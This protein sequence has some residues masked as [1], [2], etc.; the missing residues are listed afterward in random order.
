MKLILILSI[1]LSTDLIFQEEDFDLNKIEF[2][3]LSFFVTKSE[4][5]TK[6]G[7]PRINEP[8]Y[9]CGFYSNDQPS[10]PFYQLV[11]EDFNYIGSDQEKFL[12]EEVLF[13]KEG[14]ITIKYDEQKLNGLTTKKGFA[15]IFG[16]Y[17]K[18]LIDKYPEEKAFILFSNESDDGARFTFE[19]GKLIKFEY[20]SPC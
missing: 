4:V 12:L 13:D 16:S 11:Y 10:G 19:S 17:A 20:W 14:Q 8:N 6:F 7:N 15:A 5:V 2:Q 18:D 9:E 1:A 3:G